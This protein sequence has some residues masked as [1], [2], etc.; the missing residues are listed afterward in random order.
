MEDE[1]KKPPEPKGWIS[2]GSEREIEEES[3]KETR[4][5]VPWFQ[6]LHVK[7]I[8]LVHLSTITPLCSVPCQLHYM[9]SR[10]RRMFGAPVCFSDRNAADDQA[11]FIECVSY[12]DSAFS[13][14]RMQGDCGMQAVPKLQDNSAQTLWYISKSHHLPV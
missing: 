11:G 8:F 14:K 6:D 7:C 9:F 1:V 10:V 3:V 5:K 2:L 13:I 4:K 12:Q